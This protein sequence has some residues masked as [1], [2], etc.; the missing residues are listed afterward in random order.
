LSPCGG[1]SCVCWPSREVVNKVVGGGVE[2]GGISSDAILVFALFAF[3]LTRTAESSFYVQMS[4]HSPSR[5]QSGTGITGFISVHPL[6]RTHPQRH[7]TSFHFI[8]FCSSHQIQYLPKM[9][10]VH[11]TK[12]HF[13]CYCYTT[14]IA[15]IIRS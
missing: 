8:F 6:L 13:M 10:T 2:K 5:R 15:W 11:T 14:V 9:Y 7:L 12:R 4:A 3:C 1:F